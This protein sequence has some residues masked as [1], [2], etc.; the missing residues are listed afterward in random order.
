M[1][2]GERTSSK[3]E[4][5]GPILIVFAVSLLLTIPILRSGIP[6]GYDSAEHLSW[7]RCFVAQ[8]WA[9][10]LYPRWLQGMN[11]GLGSPDLFVY[12]P[13]PYYA[14]A[15]F[16]V[17]MAPGQEVY[18][19][20]FSM[21][22]AL[23]LGG[24]GA[25]LWLKQLVGSRRAACIGAVVYMAAPYYVRTD[26]YRRAA[27]A[28]FWA[29]AW[30]PL[31]LYFVV[32][33]HQRR[34]PAALAGLAVSW[35]LLFASHLF[36]AMLFAP[37]PL[38]YAVLL[39]RPRERAASL[40]A[41]LSGMLLG[42]ALSAAYLFPA[43][44]HEKYISAYRLIQTRPDYRFERN[45]LFSN[46]A[47]TEY[48]TQLSWFTAWTVMVAA[49]F[50]VAALLAKRTRLRREATWWAA[51]AG[52]SV[53]L[54]LPESRWLWKLLPLLSAVQFPSRFN[55]LLT[56][57]AAALAA[58]ALESLFSD[59]GW[60]KATV[61]GCALLLAA[62]WTIPMFRTM[63]YWYSP[64][65]Q[66]LAVDYLITAWAQWTNPKLVSL[67]GIPVDAAAPKVTA[68]HGTARVLRWEPR[69]IEFQVDSPSQTPVTVKQFYFPGWTAALADGRPLAVRPSSPEGL[70]A[71]EVPAGASDVRLRLAYGISES[72][73]AVVSA[74]TAAGLLLLALWGRPPGLPFLSRCPPPP[75]N[76]VHEDRVS[77]P[78]HRRIGVNHAKG[79][80][81]AFLLS[82]GYGM[83]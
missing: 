75:R 74:I 8:L 12:S 30:M 49:I 11:A 64:V 42:A 40:W 57:A 78:C 69:S 76:M 82:K 21:V 3:L 17:F 52:G 68:G 33:L 39:A 83:E 67:F 32:R 34:T 47:P 10:E 65:R 15:L 51:V 18:E 2:S 26:L 9:G 24:A 45:F 55:T 80:S 54:M 44:T 20:G 79:P 59:W 46:V 7:Y 70:M 37:A 22:A 50:F 81:P 58:V 62:G 66:R 53:L 23:F 6:L 56:V 77:H 61:T 14:A 72:A 16:H 63:R 71:I 19:L 25:Y 5:L 38:L 1:P 36:T 41:A 27:V 28:E 73:G 35:G 48:L 29:F 60:R 13:L 4:N 31:I 43:L